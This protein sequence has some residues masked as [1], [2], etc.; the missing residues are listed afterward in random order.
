M[1]N[2]TVHA[3]ILAG[4]P[5]A[6]LTLVT[7]ETAERWLERNE[8]NRNIRPAHVAAMA[9]DMV[10]GHWQLTGEAIKFD[11]DGRLI[12]GQHRLTA[13]VLSGV[14]VQMLV[15]SGLRSESQQVMDTGAKR[16]AFDAL[17]LRGDGTK[18]RVPLASAAR[19]ALAWDRG[20]IVRVTSGIPQ[21]TNAEILAYVDLNPSLQ[22]A[23]DDAR[24]WTE[25]GRSR[26]VAAFALD[27]LRSI[28]RDAADRFYRD[29][30]DYRTDGP[31][32]PRLALLRRLHAADKTRE[33][34]P[35][36]MELYFIF[37]T[38]NAVRSGEQLKILKTHAKTPMV[39]PR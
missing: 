28:D 14:G 1:S 20:Q 36:P 3:D 12:D 16:T 5:T 35:H 19:L 27:R 39:A 11:T 31:G 21:S 17:G 10:A 18:N 23:V 6:K 22:D 33:I 32:D 9:R 7:P 29:L 38:W 13:V 34:L 4:R 24:Q 25:V 15:V 26:A 2:T 30:M 37:R 8:S